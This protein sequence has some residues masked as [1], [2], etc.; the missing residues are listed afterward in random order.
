M[1]TTRKAPLRVVRAP[2]QIYQLRIE[3]QYL[4]PAIWRRVLVPGSIKL[5]KFHVV[6]L[7][8]MGWQ[9]G[10]MHEFVIGQTNYGEPDPEFPQ[11]PPVVREDRVILQQALGGLKT[12]RYIYDFGDDWEHKIKLEKTLP[13]DPEMKHPRCIAGQYACPPL[14]AAEPFNPLRPLFVPLRRRLRSA[15]LAR[16]RFAPGRFSVGS[17]SSIQ[18]RVVTGYVSSSSTLKRLGSNKN[19]HVSAPF[20]AGLS[21]SSDI[22]CP[23]RL[24]VKCSNIWS[25]PCLRSD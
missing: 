17:R 2:A 1:A 5:S 18:R 16:P 15:H 23:I 9:G 7:W 21:N 22:C 25:H 11:V 3:L 19:V 10:H 6:I 8:S 12:I 4:K 13:F 14:E 24:A 20:A